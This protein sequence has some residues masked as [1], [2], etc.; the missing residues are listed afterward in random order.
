MFQVDNDFYISLLSC[1]SNMKIFSANVT[2]IA[3]T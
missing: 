3:R 2:S 1:A